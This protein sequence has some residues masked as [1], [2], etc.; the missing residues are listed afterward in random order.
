MNNHIDIE[1]TLVMA[2]HLAQLSEVLLRGGLAR[3]V[4]RL[5]G[6]VQVSAGVV[7]GGLRLAHGA[8]RVT[9]GP[10]G[11]ALA[12]LGNAHGLIRSFHAVQTAD[13][14]HNRRLIC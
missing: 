10:A 11:A 9:Q 13:N 5:L 8:V 12:N 7:E 4:A 14:I 1:T 6:D 2:A 3:P